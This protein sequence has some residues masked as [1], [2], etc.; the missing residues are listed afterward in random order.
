MKTR[1]DKEKMACEAD[2]ELLL[3][4]LIDLVRRGAHNYYAYVGADRDDMLENF[5]VTRDEILKR[6]EASGASE[7]APN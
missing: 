7:R 1:E 3:N 5:D 6:M 2:S 4:T